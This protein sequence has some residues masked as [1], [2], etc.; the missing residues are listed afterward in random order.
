[1]SNNSNPYDIDG[2]QVK[3][4]TY[5]NNVVRAT[6]LDVLP[7]IHSV[8]VNP[9]GEESPIL[10]PVLTPT[11][12]THILPN[13]GQ[14][15]TLLYITENTPIVLGGVYLADSDKPPQVNEGNILIGNE[16]GAGITITSDG[17]VEIDSSD[18]GSVYIDG[19]EQ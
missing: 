13:E 19:V 2:K 9:R 15:V 6:V 18:D 11:A 16:S 10:A 5:T 4:K 7:D 1:M 8:R 17:D 12:G 3:Q 14:R